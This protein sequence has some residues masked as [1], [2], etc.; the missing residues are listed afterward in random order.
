LPPIVRAIAAIVL[1]V[2]LSTLGKIILQSVANTNLS[3]AWVVF[4]SGAIAAILGY[5]FKLPNWW[6]PINLTFPIATYLC[7]FISIPIWVFPVCFGVLILIFWNTAIER[8]PLY[9]SNPTTWRAIGDLTAQ[10]SGTFLDLGCGLGGLLL[11]LSKRYPEKFYVG[12]ES[13][14]LP[15]MIAKFRQIISPQINIEIRYGN[16]W[17][18]DFGFYGTIYAFL[19]PAPMERLL[20]KI[21]NEMPKGG[22]FISNSFATPKIE[23]SQIVTLEDNRQTKLYIWNF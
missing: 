23:Q 13:A 16:F 4:S 18:Q 17:N 2:A 20:E 10:Q 7:L 15:Y 12:I 9:L 8:V 3:F 21:S 19:S 6:I 14:P 11:Y 5:L 22:F 1:G